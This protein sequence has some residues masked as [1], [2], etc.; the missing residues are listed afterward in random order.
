M[1]SDLANAGPR[2]GC[3]AVIL[4]GSRVFLLRRARAPE[5]GCWGIA[6]GKVD[7]FETVPDAVRREVEE[8]TGLTLQHID[9]ICVVDQ[10]DRATGDHWVS[11]A[12]LAEAFTG[13]PRNCEPEKHTAIGWFELDDLPQPLT[14]ATVT[15]LAALRGR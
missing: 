13:E 6:G 11:P 5:A 9:L 4:R 3:G 15:A 14:V 1:A 7:P 2:V 8:E 12:Y 10:I